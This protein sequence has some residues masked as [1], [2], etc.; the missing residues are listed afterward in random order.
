MYY[1]IVLSIV[2]STTPD[3]EDT[4]SRLRCNV[5]IALNDVRLLLEPSEANI[6]A[7]VLLAVHV[8]EFHHSLTL[9]DARV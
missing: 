4:K 6:Q 7:L 3:D 5:W 8:E 1:S 2:S 9:L